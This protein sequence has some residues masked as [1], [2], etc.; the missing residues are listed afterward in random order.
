LF[1]KNLKE[2]RKV[3]VCENLFNKLFKNYEENPKCKNREIFINIIE[4]IIRNKGQIKNIKIK[5]NNESLFFEFFRE[6][7]KRVL[8]GNRIIIDKEIEYNSS[9]IARKRL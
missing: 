4:S 6:A 2:S 7:E 9:Q 1:I 5:N 3:N 8:S